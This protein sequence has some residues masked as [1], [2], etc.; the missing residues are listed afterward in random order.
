M[1]LLHPGV[2]IQEVSSGVRPIEG[3]STSTAAFI[4]KAQM[5]PLDK[6]VLITSLLPEF[7]NAFGDVSARQLSGARRLPVL[8]QRRQE[9]LRRAGG[10]PRRAAGRDHDQRSEVRAPPTR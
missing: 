4:G 1:E 8:Q 6:A 5:G 7:D 2:Y 9:V 3:V 10:R